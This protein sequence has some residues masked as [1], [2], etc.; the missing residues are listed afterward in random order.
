MRIILY[1]GKGGVGKTTI[2]AATGIRLAALGYKTIVIS[3]D[4]A[5][6]LRD[7][8]DNHE[9]LVRQREEKQIQISENLWIQEINVQEAIVEYWDD[10]Y[11]Y[12]RSLLNRSGLDNLVA[13]EIAVFPGM[14]EIC[15]LLYINQYV[16]E[17][18]YD[19]II[20]DCA[21]TGESLRFVSI[22]TTLEWYMNHIFKLERSL[23]KVAGP[24]IERVSSVPIPKDNYFQNI[25]DLFDKL[26]GIDDVLTDPKITTVRLVTNPEKIVIKETQRAFMYFCLY[27]LCIDAII[28]NRIFPDGVD[29]AY[30]EAW[31][32]T[33]QHYIEEAVNYFSDVPIWKVNLFAEEIVGEAGLHRLAD[34][35]YAEIDPAVQ[36]SNESPY[37]FRKTAD[38]Y[39][40]SMRLPFLSKE[41]IGLTKH[42][43]ELI[44]TVGNFKR[45]VALPRSL[46][47]KKTT[48]AKLT[49]DQLVIKFQGDSSR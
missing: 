20:L 45:H 22:P 8:F 1:T 30:F 25:Q 42:G 28:I 4:V 5:H 11:N 41:E 34:A 10:V 7:A 2:A 24:V 43:D 6:S 47:N 23:A 39:Q 3:L 12:I 33:Q 40:L 9:K 21:P 46:S 29:G 44:I 48:G 13:E 49:G 14:E 19:V 16:R 26:E 36:F 37:Q 38:A 17:K 15:A 27:G 31:K 32:Q 18:Q 35:L